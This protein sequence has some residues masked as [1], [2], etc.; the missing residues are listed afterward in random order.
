MPPVASQCWLVPSLNM[1]GAEHWVVMAGGK[2]LDPS[3]RKKYGTYSE[4]SKLG[5]AILVGAAA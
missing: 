5:G 4:I 1:A 2:L 3:R